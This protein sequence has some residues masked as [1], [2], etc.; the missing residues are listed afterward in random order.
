M[1]ILSSK[2]RAAVAKRHPNIP[3]DGFE[4]IGPAWP[5]L[6]APADSGKEE[7]QLE[8]QLRSLQP[9][10]GFI[11]ATMGPR[12]TYQMASNDSR[13]RIGSLKRQVNALNSIRA[14]I[15]EFPSD[16]RE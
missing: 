7:T 4:G 16:D 8:A 13:H 5:P 3:Q 12:Y 15:L 1:G 14:A 9:V 2:D 10:V 11:N 6:S